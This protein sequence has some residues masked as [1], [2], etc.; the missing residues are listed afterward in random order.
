[1]ALMLGKCSVTEALLGFNNNFEISTLKLNA[2]F[3]FGTLSWIATLKYT[4]KLRHTPYPYP[5][6]IKTTH[7]TSA[8]LPT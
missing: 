3:V 6:D 8:H 2:L 1:M 7:Q 4:E 5:Q